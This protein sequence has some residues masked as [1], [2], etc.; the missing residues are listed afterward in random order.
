MPP[1]D[2]KNIEHNLKA[3]G[4][5]FGSRILNLTLPPPRLC[6]IKMLISCTIDNQLV[7]TFVTY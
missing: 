4:T 7:E 3:I 1:F 6:D 2:Y 5:F